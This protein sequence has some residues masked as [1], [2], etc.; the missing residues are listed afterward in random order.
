MRQHFYDEPKVYFMHI[1][2]HGP[3][4]EL[5]ANVKAIW[6]A[7][8]QIRAANPSPA[9]QFPNPI[10]NPTGN[11]DTELISNYMSSPCIIT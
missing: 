5:A 9:I 3:A 8:R 10:S 6:G 1:E 11:P 7:I 4:I 2:G